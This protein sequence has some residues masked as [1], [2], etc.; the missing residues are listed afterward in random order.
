MP[1]ECRAHIH[2]ELIHF[3]QWRFTIQ[4]WVN[5]ID[6][7]IERHGDLS[8]NLEVNNGKTAAYIANRIKALVQNKKPQ[9]VLIHCGTNDLE[10]YSKP[11]LESSFK[12]IIKELRWHTGGTNIVLSGLIHRLDKPYLNSRIDAVN[13]FLQSLETKDVIF[14][15]HN[16]TFR[17][18]TKVL[19]NKGL[20]LHQAGK[21]QVAEN[22]YLAMLGT[23]R[24]PEGNKENT[25][26][27]GQHDSDMRGDHSRS[28]RHTPHEPQRDRYRRSSWNRHH[29]HETG[30]GLHS[31]HTNQRQYHVPAQQHRSQYTNNNS[32]SQRYSRSTP[33]PDYHSHFQRAHNM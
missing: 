20:H 27:M 23:S 9:H 18:L 30:R 32:R 6:K 33:E 11:E 14:V 21:R 10:T 29:E 13:T 16:P 8:V 7:D 12:S 25:A 3:F 24:N 4:K 31:A 17:D 15:N 28:T 1:S 22:F 19:N 26:E 2:K 5:P